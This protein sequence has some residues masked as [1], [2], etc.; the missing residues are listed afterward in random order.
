M[1]T[2][3]LSRLKV[4]ALNPG[5]DMSPQQMLENLSSGL[6][7]ILTPFIPKELIAKAGKKQTLVRIGRPGQAKAVN[8][9]LEGLDF[10]TTLKSPFGYV[11]GVRQD[12]DGSATI[13][14]YENHTGVTVVTS[15]SKA[16]NP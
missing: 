13:V 5:Q 3:A 6:Q 7:T 12:I 8:K 4:Q 9:M 15:S 1:K 2:Q 16:F 14:H 10:T 11:G